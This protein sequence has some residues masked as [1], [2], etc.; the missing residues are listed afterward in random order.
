MGDAVNFTSKLPFEIMDEML[1]DIR[2]V[3]NMRYQEEKLSHESTKSRLDYYQHKNLQFSSNIKKYIKYLSNIIIMLIL[4]IGAVGLIFTIYPFFSV[5]NK[6]LSWFSI[7]IYSVLSFLSICTLFNKK[8]R[9]NIE[10]SLF[11]C[12][13]RLVFGKNDEIV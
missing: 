11:N 13:H 4:A 5:P 12:I 2:K 3:E 7:I 10:L 6:H 1:K 9:Q 8:F